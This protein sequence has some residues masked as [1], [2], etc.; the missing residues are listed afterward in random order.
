MILIGRF[1]YSV[2]KGFRRKWKSDF[3]FIFFDAG[4][5]GFMENLKSSCKVGKP[6]ATLIMLHNLCNVDITIGNIHKK[7]CRLETLNS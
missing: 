7:N 4:S 3:R 6:L 5:K 2:A 1:M